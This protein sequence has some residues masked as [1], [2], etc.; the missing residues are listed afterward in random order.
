MASKRKKSSKRKKQLTRNEMLKLEKKQLIKLC[1]KKKVSYNGTKSDMVQRILQKRHKHKQQKPSKLSPIPLKQS[2]TNLAEEGGEINIK[3]PKNNKLKKPKPRHK[4]TKTSI[5]NEMLKLN[6]KELVKKCKDVGVSTTGTKSEMIRRII[7][8]SANIPTT[9]RKTR[10][11]WF[12]RLNEV[13]EFGFK[14]K[15]DYLI[16]GFMSDVDPTRT[17]CPFDL[18]LLLASYS[19]GVLELKFDNAAGDGNTADIKHQ[20]TFIFFPCYADYILILFLFVIVNEGTLIVRNEANGNNRYWCSKPFG[21]GKHDF[22]IKFK[23]KSHS[24]IPFD[25]IGI[26]RRCVKAKQV[27]YRGWG[28]RNRFE[29]NW[30]PSL[31]SYGNNSY[32]ISNKDKNVQYLLPKE[33][34]TRG[35]K[36][37]NYIPWI[38]NDV[39]TIR[40][41]C[42]KWTVEFKIN[43]KRMGQKIKIPEG[44]YYAIA[45][46]NS[47]KCEY[48]LVY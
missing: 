20:G 35:I 37:D 23:C 15:A 31:R 22:H 13:N 43:N 21:I 28:Y 7:N 30:E 2:F 5:R 10:D 33:H 8:K 34:M 36:C 17:L 40:L 9:E 39:I 27:R 3:K 11:K 1:K 47:N 25:C 16:A 6:K 32:F 38:S 41:D 4:R 44:N 26:T 19:G 42:N 46:L 14:M 45:E 48:K 18:I 29:W 24:R 12:K